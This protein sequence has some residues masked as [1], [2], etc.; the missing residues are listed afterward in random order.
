MKG[1][2]LIRVALTGIFVFAAIQIGFAQDINGAKT[3]YNDALQNLKSNPAAAI[4]SLEN[5]VSICE[6]IGAP[7][8]S[9]KNAAESKFA[10][11]YYN[12]ALTEARAK[13]FEEAAGNFLLAKKFGE[14]TN[15][16]EVLDRALPAL[17]RIYA[18]I[19]N[20]YLGKKD[21]TLAQEN[22]EKALAI[23]STDPTAWLVQTRIYQDMDNPEGVQ[24]AIAKCLQYSKNPNETRQAQQS[25]MVYFLTRGSKDVN[26]NKFE[27]G[28]ADLEKALSY[29]EN[30]K[31]IL[32]YLAKGY[33]G[34]AQWD[35]AIDAAQKGIAIEE[36][37]PEKEA[38]YWYEIG[39]AYKGKND[40]TQACEAFKKAMAGQ[41]VDNAKYEIEVDLKCGK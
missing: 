17:V 32:A 7:A 35:K 29:D 38:K 11:T 27:E 14:Q 19:S 5:C 37:V 34:L 10:E 3:A 40:K 39:M 20:S 28:V 30:N 12:L 22:I 31:D 41:Y 8:D 9:V 1:M 33:N 6:K 25:G 26:M 36:D 21:T 13:K 2:K 15:N 23:D 18:M 4:K 16:K 24:K